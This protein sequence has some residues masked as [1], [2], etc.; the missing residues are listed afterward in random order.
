MNDNDFNEMIKKAQSMIQNNQ[1]PDDIKAL[2]NNLQNSN[3]NTSNV[4]Y[5][6]SNNVTTNGSS[7][8]SNNAYNTYKNNNYK[9]GTYTSNSNNYSSNYHSSSNH[10]GNSDSNYNSRNFNKTN[11]NSNF[12]DKDSS[13]NNT[14]YSSTSNEQNNSNNN[15][16]SMN[17]D[18]ETLM[19]I[20]SIMSKMKN[21]SDDDMSKLLLSLKPY[22]RNGKKEKIDE[23]I[24]LIKMGKMTQLFDLFGGEK[25]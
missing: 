24:Q 1:I 16:N 21:S 17:I 18:M 7:N 11:I 20:Q 25:K 23:Y 8:V 4:S 13:S 2:V 10:T 14:Y 15:L 12:Q 6:S 22:L 19:K 9:N 5:N 3:S